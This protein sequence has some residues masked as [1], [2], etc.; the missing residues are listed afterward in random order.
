MNC[1]SMQSQL[2]SQLKYS[3]SE[4][5]IDGPI[6]SLPVRLLKPLCAKLALDI[7][8]DVDG[9]GGNWR[10][11]AGHI[12]LPMA[13]IEL[14]ESFKDRT[15]PHTLFKIWDEGISRN[16]GSI[17][18]LIIALFELGISYLEDDLL[19]PLMGKVYLIVLL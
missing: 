16:P 5:D 13:M 10:D 14:I 4:L 18:K 8:V 11:L 6:C 12:G 2:R 15:K 7:S 1:S 19:I 3:G 9:H 17:R